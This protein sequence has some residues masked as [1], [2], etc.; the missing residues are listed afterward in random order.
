MNYSSYQ[1]DDMFDLLLMAEQAYNS[2]TSES[3]EVSPSYT[4]YGYQPHTGC[5][6]PKLKWD[7]LDPT[8]EILDMHWKDTSMKRR[9]NVLK[10]PE[11]QQKWYDKCHKKTLELEVGSQVLLDRRDIRTKRQ[12]GQLGHKRFGLFKVQEK[13]SLTLNPVNLPGNGKFTVYFMSV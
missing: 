7:S 4:N 11:R 12:S 2:A 13:V 8:S 1:Q 5:P 3:F 10:A 9:T 6:S